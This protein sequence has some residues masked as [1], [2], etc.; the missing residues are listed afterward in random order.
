M[1]TGRDNGSFHFD[2]IFPFAVLNAQSLSP[3]RLGS[4]MALYDNIEAE[5]KK[6]KQTY[7]FDMSR[8]PKNIYTSTFIPLIFLLLPHHK[9]LNKPPSP[10]PADLLIF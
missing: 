8:L 7:S 6:V 2:L 5:E 10:L 1:E 9:H 4:L 3:N